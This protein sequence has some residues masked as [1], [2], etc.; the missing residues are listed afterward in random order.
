M[1]VVSLYDESHER[2]LLLSDFNLFLDLE[3]KPKTEHH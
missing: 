1:C 3:I 2:L